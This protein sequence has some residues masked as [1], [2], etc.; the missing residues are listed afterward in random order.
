M[1]FDLDADLALALITSENTRVTVPLFGEFDPFPGHQ[2]MP[3]TLHVCVP[4]KRRFN[5]K[6]PL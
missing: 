5:D 4:G 2:R 3:D 6:Q 1:Q